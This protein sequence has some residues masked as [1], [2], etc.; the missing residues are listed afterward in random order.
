MA[1]S[2]DMVVITQTG[3][4]KTIVFALPAILHINAY[5]NCLVIQAIS[6]VLPQPSFVGSVMALSILYLLQL[7]NLLCKFSRS[8]LSLALTHAFATLPSVVGHPNL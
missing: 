2:G 6:F 7:V 4:G 1:L 3:S 5:M 8:V